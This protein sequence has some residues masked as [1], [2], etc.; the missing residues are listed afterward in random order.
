MTDP[1]DPQL[2]DQPRVVHFM[3]SLEIGG[4]ER[5]VLDL[6]ERARAR[7][8]D[9]RLLVCDHAFRDRALDFDPGD[10][11]VEFI[12][13]R[14]GLDLRFARRIRRWFREVG[15]EVV[16]AHNDTPIFYAALAG[17]FP[18]PGRPR[19]VGTFHNLPTHGGPR[20][21]LLTRWATRR[22]TTM[23]SVSAELGERLTQLGWSRP[24]RT[25]GNGI[26]LD[27]FQPT[28]SRGNWREQLGVGEE[29]FLVGLLARFVPVKRQQDLLEAGRKL[30]AAGL[31][32]TLVFIGRGPDRARFEG[33][34]DKNEPVH[35]FDRVE[36]VPAW[37]RAL[38]AFVLCSEH[39]AA[40][41]A[42]M[43][44][45]ACGRACVAT[46]V[47]GIP[48]LVRDR[49]G[50]AAVALVPPSDVDSLASVLESL[51]RSEDQRTALGEAARVRAGSF[52]LERPWQKYLEIW[53]D[54][55]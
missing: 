17:L 43:E 42:L 48:D 35:V 13:R 37:L 32:V 27:N 52:S 7:S 51:L 18:G 50:R 5:V 11:P 54:L 20:A 29:G 3:H 12:P 55:A 39:E 6:V 9:H 34:L 41:R 4:V 26:D 21:R 22:A 53:S 44:A 16:H 1:R 25:V 14:P 19:L 28:G 33:R 45:M 8:L 47:G 2:D 49:D 15:A 31:P 24:S 23:T 36:E 46:T 10:L 38:D 40:P 30:R